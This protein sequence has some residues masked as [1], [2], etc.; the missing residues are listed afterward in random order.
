MGLK[1][2]REAGMRKINFAG[3]EPFLYPKRLGRLVEFC[4]KDLGM[5]SVSILTN[6]GRVT[7]RFLSRFGRYIDIIDMS[8][9][10]FREDVNVKTGRGRGSH[11]RNVLH[12]SR[13]CR[14]YGIKF[15]VNTVVSKFNFEEDMNKY[16]SEIDPF[17]W[18]CFQVLIIEGE[19]N[20][21]STQ[22]NAAPFAI[23]GEEF[24]KF[25]QVHSHHKCFVAEPNNVMKSF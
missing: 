10:S 15:K 23:T 4:K 7:K 8:C 16:I 18:N 9:D 21:D 11:L 17:Q 3:G 20:P 12:L 5:E 19:N 22:R 14:Q 24:G 13:L 2:L 1:L 6:E 25:C